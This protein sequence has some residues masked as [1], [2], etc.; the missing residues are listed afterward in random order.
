MFNYKG[1]A[2]LRKNTDILYG[3]IS[4]EYI[5]MI[6]IQSS[7]KVGDMNVADKVTACMLPTLAVTDAGIDFTQIARSAKRDGLY[8][9]LDTAYTWLSSLK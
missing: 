4:D 6:N 7:H 9:A 3:N 8:S 2:L 5:C 1:Y